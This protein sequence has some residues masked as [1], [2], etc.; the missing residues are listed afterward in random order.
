MRDRLE[1]TF[2]ETQSNER[3]RRVL[4]TRD[5]DTGTYDYVEGFWNGCTWAPRGHEIVTDLEIEGTLPGTAMLAAP[6][7]GTSLQAIRD[8]LEQALEDETD[9][10]FHVRQALQL[11]EAA[12]EDSR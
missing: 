4:E 6:D 3:R 11:V 5:T 2:L 1:V 10:R 8:Q 7:G 12:E 9:T